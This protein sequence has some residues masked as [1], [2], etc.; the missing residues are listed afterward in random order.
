MNFGPLEIGIVAVFLLILYT[1]F[2]TFHKME[3]DGVAKWI[4]LLLFLFVPAVFPIAY[5]A[6]DVVRRIRN[7]RKRNKTG[8]MWLI[9][10]G[11]DKKTADT[12]PS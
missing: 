10:Q 6:V 3:K 12:Q 9:D 11:K 4:I 2:Y 8:I 5:T 1:Y 7:R